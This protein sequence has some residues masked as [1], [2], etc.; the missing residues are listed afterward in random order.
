MTRARRAVLACAAGLLGIPMAGTAHAVP[1][2]GAIN[3]TWTQPFT[4]PLVTFSGVFATWNCT[5]TTWPTTGPFTVT[6]T[7][8]PAS[9]PWE[10]DFL[11]VGSHGMSLTSAVRTTMRCD[12]IQA[13]QTATINGFG[14]DRVMAL[15]GLTANQSVTCTVDNGGALMAV[16]DFAGVCGDPPSLG[17]LEG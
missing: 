10:C 16:P 9:G 5:Q 3:I 2:T 4:A 15:S 1:V 11:V 14:G 8:P 6:C 17:L 7:P 13:A 12:G